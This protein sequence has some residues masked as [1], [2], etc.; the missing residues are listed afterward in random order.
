MLIRLNI[1][2]RGFT[3]IEI[4]IALIIFS[5]A[6]LWLFSLQTR[7]FS[8]SLDLGQRSV[9]A[10]VLQDYSSRVRSNPTVA[11][12][13]RGTFNQS[14]CDT[15]SLSCADSNGAEASAC[16]STQIAAHDQWAAFC[17]GVNSSKLEDKVIGWEISVSCTDA[18]AN[19]T[20]ASAQMQV[21]GSWSR[22]RGRTDKA[23]QG[24]ALVDLLGT[25]AVEKSTDSDQM[26]LVFSPW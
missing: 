21:V 3:L 13:Y 7:S 26:V 18:A 1:S 5:I 6:V 22:Q 23:I 19:C 25:G 12:E 24:N 17:G 20:D 2:Q 16:S 4:L 8:T 11:S 9:M 14:S 10:S 15:P